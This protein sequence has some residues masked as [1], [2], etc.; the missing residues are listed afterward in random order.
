MVFCICMMLLGCNAAE[1]ELSGQ[2]L[3]DK[4]IEAHGGASFFDS[5]VSFDID[6]RHYLVAWQNKSPRFEVTRATDSITY[7]ATYSGGLQQYF[8]NDS[9]QEETLYTRRYIDSQL[10]G[11]LY[12]F[13]IP[14][15]FD[16]NAVIATR[17][18]DV[19]VKDKKYHSVHISFT[20]I[21]E[22]EGDEFYLYID[23]ETYLVDYYAEKY[24]LT[25]ERML[26]K[27]AFN[28]RTINGYVFADY[29]LFEDRSQF[30]WHA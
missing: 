16:Q 26:F 18:E 6:D 4:S 14:H 25:G 8:I 7:K 5:K 3:L 9:L 29:Y 20:Q 30:H 28:R 11:L 27:R 22:N 23:P 19:L 2:Q 12:L 1:T 21:D 10:E 24:E 15:I 13:S 17:V